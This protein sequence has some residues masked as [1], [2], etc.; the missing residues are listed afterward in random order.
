MGL[1]FFRENYGFMFL[2]EKLQVYVFGGKITGLRFFG[3]KYY[4]LM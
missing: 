4:F 2:A 1:H 3:G